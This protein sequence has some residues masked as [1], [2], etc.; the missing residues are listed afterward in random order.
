MTTEQ[1]QS[2]YSLLNELPEDW[3]FL[4]C[5]FCMDG[6]PR[7]NCATNLSTRGAVTLVSLL[8][9]ELSKRSLREIMEAK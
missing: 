3:G 6:D 1:Q 5:T 8:G 4:V 2:I 7:I 9:G